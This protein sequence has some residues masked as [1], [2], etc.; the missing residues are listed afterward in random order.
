MFLIWI[1]DLIDTMDYLPQEVK[2]MQE[3]VIVAYMQ[4]PKYWRH[5]QNRAYFN[6]SL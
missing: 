6:L 1:S 3:A 5:V 2:A 4:R